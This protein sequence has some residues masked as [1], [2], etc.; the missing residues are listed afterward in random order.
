MKHLRFISKLKIY[1]VSFMLAMLPPAIHWYSVDKLSAT[2]LGYGGVAL[3]GTATVL[4]IISHFFSK[5][6]GE[7]YYNPEDDVIR[8]ST[9]TFLGNRK[10]E[11]FPSADIVMFIESQGRM[12]GTFQRLELRGHKKVYVWS[13]QYGR[14]QDLDRLCEVLRI[15]DTDLSHF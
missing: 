4:G 15:S 12:G 9:L 7:L 2:A 3:L 13:I 10:E 11:K 14:V 8:I 1:Q 5:L 6:V